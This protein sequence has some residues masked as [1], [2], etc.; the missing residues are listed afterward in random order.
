M[1]PS[2]LLF[3]FLS[4][5]LIPP[6]NTLGQNLEDFEDEAGGTTTFNSNGTITFSMSSQSGETYKVFEDG[7]VDNG[8]ADD[9]SAC[10]WNGTAVDQKFIDN[11]S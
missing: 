8:F 2:P 6:H 10:G 5:C 3:S 9:C 11:T 1:K 4:I 7:F